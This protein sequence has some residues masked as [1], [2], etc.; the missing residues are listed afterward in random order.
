MSL[1]SRSLLFS[2]VSALSLAAQSTGETW[3]PEQAPI[4]CP[5]YY[6]FVNAGPATLLYDPCGFAVYDAAGA[7]VFTPPC[8]GP[9]VLQAHEFHAQRWTQVDSAGQPVPPGTYHLNGP[10]GPAVVVGGVEAAVAPIGSRKFELCSPL[11]AGFCYVMGAALSN[12]TGIRICA[13]TVP[14][15]PD[16]L[17]RLS[18]TRPAI[19]PGFAGVLDAN[20]MAAA[21]VVYPNNIGALQI[22]L[23]FVVL[24]PAAPC[25]VRRISAPTRTTIF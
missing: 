5:I 8:A 15:D 13:G 9:V 25:G 22:H 23:A 11:D 18:L 4:G 6:S 24:D 21:R 10:G 2:F 7:L 12:T 20:G 1:F 17:L 14:L 19:F 3:G 16:R